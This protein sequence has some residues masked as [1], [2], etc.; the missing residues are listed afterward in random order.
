MA[1]R[2]YKPTTP[3]TR[4]RMVLTFDEVTSSTP[5]KSL[6]RRRKQKSGRNNNG[7]ITVRRRGG[8]NKRKYR[9]VDFKRDKAGIPAKVAAIHYDPNRSANIALLYYVDGEKRYIVAPNGLKVGD[10]LLSGK[11]AEFNTGNAMSLRSI[12][13]GTFIHNI[14][15][16][17]GK[18]AQL[19]RSA[20]AGA[21]L[22]SKEGDYALVK[23]PSNEM[24]LVH[25]DC[26]ATIGVVGNEDHANVSAGKAGAS[27]WKGRRPKVRGV[28]MNPVDHP[29][30]G[31]EGKTS[32]GRH[33]VSPTGVKAKGLRTR[34]KSKPSNKFVVK[35]RK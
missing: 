5:E 32:G 4:H 6:L 30:G 18:G 16:K 9:L 23:L 1:I 13:L 21:Q 15:L 20:G 35:R 14:E 34:K 10:Q 29:H 28:A 2:A 27:R 25:L 19:V 8:G 17:P 31:G 22:M 12:P 33:P 7:H 11:D 3:A 24:R 26:L